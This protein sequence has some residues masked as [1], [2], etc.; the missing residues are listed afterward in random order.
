LTNRCIALYINKRD[1][2]LLFKISAVWLALGAVTIH[3]QVVS[4]PIRAE[5]S[6]ADAPEQGWT[7]GDRIPLRLTVIY[8]ADLDVTLPELPETWGA[9]EVREQNQRDPVNNFDGTITAIREATVTL[10]A[11]GDH[12]TP[13]LI[14]THPDVNGKLYETSV[15]P[16]TLSVVSVLGEG[17]TE[18]RDLKPQAWL[19]NPPVWPGFIGGLLLAA[20]IGA[21]AWI[22]LTHL[23]DR[24][25]PTA[26]PALS[27]D[28]HPPHEIAYSELNRIAALDLPAH[29]ELKRYYT[30]LGDCLRRYVQGRY[31]IPAMD[32]TTE[33]LMIAFERAHVEHGHVSLFRELLDETD[34]V[35]FAK[36]RPSVEKAHSAL[37]Q[38]RHIVDVTKM[39]ASAN[40][41]INEYARAPVA[42]GRSQNDSPAGG[43]R[44][45]P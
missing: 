36:L 30:L 2:P 14:L 31:D 34:L 37:T 3:A 43:Q 39:E 27:F 13:P 18:K 29:G 10:W 22:S 40:Q 23:R 38:A 9:F 6:V 12:Q 19:P 33:E 35:K 25:R 11:P 17:D 24:Q 8:P 20:L 4:G 1:I 45:R 5:W 16:L 41:Y 28:P 32:Q 44:S 7:V 15:P 26:E 21:L 42:D